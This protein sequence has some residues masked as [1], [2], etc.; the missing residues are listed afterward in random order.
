[1][2]RPSRR[3]RRRRSAG[4][5]TCATACP[6]RCGP[7]GATAGISATARR[8]CSG[9]TTGARG[10]RC[11][12]GP[13][14]TTTSSARPTCRPRCPEPDGAVPGAGGPARPPLRLP[15]GTGRGEREPWPQRWRRPN[16]AL[17]GPNSERQTG[18]PSAAGRGLDELVHHAA[19][20]L[21]LGP[22]V[23]LAPELDRRVDRRRVERAREP[24]AVLREALDL[25][26]EVVD[27]HR[28]VVDAGCAVRRQAVARLVEAEQLEAAGLQVEELAG[29]PE[30]VGPE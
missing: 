12:A 25:R 7:A 14:S 20:G 16:R 23:A 17:G 19:R 11:C 22:Q 4:W 5:P 10:T 24:D 29:Q 30:L 2:W 15:R 1:M 6:A 9:P 27:L 26:V 3:R 28:D 21:G 18:N 13:N 8:R